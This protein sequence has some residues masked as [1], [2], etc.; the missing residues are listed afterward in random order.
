MFWWLTHGVD[1]PEGGL[2]MPGF[3]KTLS[4]DD[5]W[6][7][8]DYVRAHNAAVAIQQ[9]SA[10]DTPVRAPALAISCSSVAAS[11]MADLHGHAVLVVLGDTV[12]EQ[13]TVP[14]PDAV[15]LLVSNDDGKPTRGSCAAADPTAW[16]AFA[17]LADLPLDEAAG[18]VFLIDPN[19]WLRAVQ[20]PGATGGWHSR[21][22]LLAA[23]RGISAHP[24]EQPSGG[25]HEHHH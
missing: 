10:F 8:I 1:D 3:A 12:P 23:I 15:T 17:I 14:A 11:A 2:A 13:T 16:N 18:A 24:I 21:D 22:D 25:S 19:G 4:E 7:L 6:A 5:R 20:R 9:D